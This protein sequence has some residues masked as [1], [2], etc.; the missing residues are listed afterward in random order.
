MS[1]TYVATILT[2][3]LL[4]ILGLGLVIQYL[5][6]TN[7]DGVFNF[8]VNSCMC[9]IKTMWLKVLWLS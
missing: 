1:A 4:P 7:S 2:R 8:V 3:C 6:I 9:C 5:G